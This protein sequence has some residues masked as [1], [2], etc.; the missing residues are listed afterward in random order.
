VERKTDCHHSA[1]LCVISGAHIVQ[2]TRN[3]RASRARHCIVTLKP[4]YIMYST[5]LRNFVNIVSASLSINIASVSANGVDLSSIPSV[6]RS[7]CRS[8][9]PESVL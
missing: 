7:V 2:L 4:I 5:S 8:F 1:E 9:C 6:G 3:T